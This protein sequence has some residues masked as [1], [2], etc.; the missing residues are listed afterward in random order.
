[1]RS[2]TQRRRTC[3]GEKMVTPAAKREA[4]AP[5]RSAFDM[6]ERGRAGLPDARY[7]PRTAPPR[8]PP[9]PLPFL[10]FSYVACATSVCVQGSVL[11]EHT[12]DVRI[13]RS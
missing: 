7:A 9:P 6:S 4:V 8:G 3:A 11:V 12:P 1:M 2:T 5:L 10:E 13:Q